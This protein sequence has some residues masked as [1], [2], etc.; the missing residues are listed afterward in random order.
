[1][2]VGNTMQFPWLPALP[3][4]GLHTDQSHE[5][6]QGR[7]GETFP[8]K[9]GGLKASSSSSMAAE[10]AEPVRGHCPFWV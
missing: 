9:M 2:W 7:G 1:M 4:C 6:T 8:P 5:R 3:A 10:R